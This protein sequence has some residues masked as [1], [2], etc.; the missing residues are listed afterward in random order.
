MRCFNDADPV[1]SLVPRSTTG[2][3]LASIRLGIHLATR[4][5][6]HAVGVQSASLGAKRIPGLLDAWFI[7]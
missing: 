2:F 1:V 6:W 7:F 4:R 3:K 5:E